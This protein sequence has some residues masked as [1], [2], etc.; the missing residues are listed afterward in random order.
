MSALAVEPEQALLEELT[1]AAAALTGFS[2]DAILPDAIR[3]AARNLL[4]SASAGELVERARRGDTALASVLSQAVTVGETFFFRHAE[5]FRFLTSRLLPELLERPPPRIR[6]WSAGCATGEEPWSIAACLHDVLPPGAPP[7]EILGTDLLPRNL[8]AAQT[9]VYGAWSQRPSAPLLHPIA[10][11]VGGSSAAARALVCVDDRLRPL[12]RF[13]QHNLL[14]PGEGD[15]FHAIFCR[16]VLVYFSPEAAARVLEHLAR[17]LAPGG[18]LLLG[19]MDVAAAP[20]GL[21]A[22]GAPQDQIWCKPDPSRPV[23][24]TTP[25]SRPVTPLQPFVR[26]AAE[27]V[28]LHL[29][30]LVHVER[31]NHSAATRALTELVREAPDYVP[32]LLERAL[33][34]VRLGER[35]AATSLMREVLR[36]S[37]ALPGDELVAAPEPLPA[38]FFVQS[39]QAFL[40]TPRGRA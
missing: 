9:G 37:A 19:S 6:I 36:R 35:A 34:H 27:P 16:N 39:A 7:V 31:G 29:R 8:A 24:Q 23:V 3:K 22:T 25:P 4:A 5:H 11:P 30:A 2:R 33:L 21:V 12:V 26:R 17:A 14:S 18:A 10:R 13:K 28:A 38:S 40:K 15:P 32:G 20:P 1:A